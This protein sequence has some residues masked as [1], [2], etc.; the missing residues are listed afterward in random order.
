[1]EDP[2]S[3]TAYELNRVSMEGRPLPS[4]QLRSVGV[5]LST[6]Y[7]TAGMAGTTPR[8]V[9]KTRPIMLRV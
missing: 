2:A 8:S 3:V 9:M 6:S 4:A 5:P 1:M 7:Y